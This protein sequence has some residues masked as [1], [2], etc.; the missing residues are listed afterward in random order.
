MRTHKHAYTSV[1][2]NVNALVCRVQIRLRFNVSYAT[3][4]PMLAGSYCEFFYWKMRL[5]SCIV[6]V[7]RAG[8]AYRLPRAAVF[9]RM[10]KHAER[11]KLTDQRLM[12]Q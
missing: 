9:I 5:V 2:R 12:L 4:V 7:S 11:V 8:G 6:N 1:H 3:R 10:L